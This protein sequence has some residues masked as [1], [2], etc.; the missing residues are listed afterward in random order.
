MDLFLVEDFKSYAAVTL[1][2]KMRK[3]SPQDFYIPSGFY[4]PG[5]CV[6]PG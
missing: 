6:G 4:K 3:S 1:V 5:T 2:S